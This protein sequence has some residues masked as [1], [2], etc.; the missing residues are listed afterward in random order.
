MMADITLNPGVSGVDA[1]ITG[2]TWV[3]GVVWVT[4]VTGVAVSI[5]CVNTRTVTTGQRMLSIP[6]S[7]DT[8]LY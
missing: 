8:T 5:P 1:W 6:L 3:T 7:N 2:V 4:R